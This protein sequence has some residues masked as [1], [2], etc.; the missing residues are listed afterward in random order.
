MFHIVAFMLEKN[1]K[2]EV[3]LSLS[4]EKQPRIYVTKKITFLWKSLKQ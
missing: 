4:S 2:F 3:E 1:Y